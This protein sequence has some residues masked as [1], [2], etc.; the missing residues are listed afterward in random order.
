MAIQYSSLHCIES[1]SI[2]TAGGTLFLL[3]NVLSFLCLIIHM[4]ITRIIIPIKTEST[5]P[6][7]TI[8]ASK[9]LLNKKIFLPVVV[10][11]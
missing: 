6:I 7:K 4:V 1:V 3:L 10:V 11:F 8:L 2:H 5:I 9:P